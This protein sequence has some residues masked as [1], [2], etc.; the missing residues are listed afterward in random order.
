MTRRAKKKHYAP[1][2]GAF[3][4]TTLRARALAPLNREISPC[5]RLHDHEIAGAE[6]CMVGY[7]GEADRVV[8]VAAAILVE[9][10]VASLRVVEN[11][12]VG[13]DMRA[14]ADRLERRGLQRACGE[15]GE[16][17][18]VKQDEV[19]VGVEIHDRVEIVRAERGAEIELVVA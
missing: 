5:Q 12:I 8:G 4:A 13:I 10:Q 2:E 18:M 3:R 16:Y 11:A 6:V 19:V 17:R 14:L 15:A 1:T 9:K 7:V